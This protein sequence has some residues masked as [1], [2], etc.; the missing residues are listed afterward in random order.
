MIRKSINKQP[1]QYFKKFVNLDFKVG[2]SP[3]KNIKLFFLMKAL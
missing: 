1:I 2:L 3:S